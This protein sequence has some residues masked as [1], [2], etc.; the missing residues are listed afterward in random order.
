MFC[1][2]CGMPALYFFNS[3]KILNKYA[4]LY[5]A[6]YLEFYIPFL[7]KHDPPSLEKKKKK[8]Q[9][10]IK[11]FCKSYKIKPYLR[12]TELILTSGFCF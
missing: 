4:L 7:K 12:W 10:L 5:L 8:H 2:E 1:D 3:L 11:F 9:S 6:L